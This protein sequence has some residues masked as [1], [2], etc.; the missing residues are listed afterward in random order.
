MEYDHHG[1]PLDGTAYRAHHQQ[2]LLW[3]AWREDTEAD[4]DFVQ[5][6]GKG[7]QHLEQMAIACHPYDLPR[8]VQFLR[9][10]IKR[11]ADQTPKLQLAAEQAW[12]TF[13]TT[14]PQETK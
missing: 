12:N 5:L 6:V 7:I 8:L 10:Q 14:H 13:T 11:T 9:H 4:P 3:W 2:D 1:N